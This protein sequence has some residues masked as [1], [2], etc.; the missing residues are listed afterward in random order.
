MSH[1]LFWSLLIPTVFI[2]VLVI[3]AFCIEHLAPRRW[4]LDD[5]DRVAD[6]R[7]RLERN[8]RNVRAGIR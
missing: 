1:Q 7:R 3:G 6:R 2:A 4:R 5:W 8:A